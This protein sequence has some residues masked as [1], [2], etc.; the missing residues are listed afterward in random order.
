MVSVL[1]GSTADDGRR[2][3]APMTTGGYWLQGLVQGQGI[4]PTVARLAL[5]HRLRGFVRNTSNGVQVEVAGCADDIQRFEQ[6]MQQKLHVNVMR[7]VCSDHPELTNE[8]E[9]RASL[10]S[11]RMKTIVPLD[12]AVCATCLDEVRSKDSRR[13]QYPFTTCTRCGPRYSILHEMPFDRERTSM[14]AFSMCGDCLDEYHHPNDRRFH[15]QTNSCAGCGPK[16]W[17]ENELFAVTAEAIEAIVHVAE[18]ILDGGIAAVKGIGGYQLV[19]DATNESVVKRLRDRKRRPTKPF[20]IMVTDIEVAQRF[21]IIDSAEASLLSSGAN[22]I[23]L[24]R[25]RGSRELAPS[26]HPRLTELG[27]MLSTTPLHYLLSAW[28]NRPLV[29]TSGNAHGYPIV[30]EIERSRTELKGIADVWMHH[31]REIVRPID[32]SVV[33]CIAGRSMT[34]RLARGMAPLTIPVSVREPM[35]GVGGHQKVAI[36][37]CTG[38]EMVLAPH[39]G[40]MDSE[41]S[42]ERFQIECAKIALLYRLESLPLACDLHPDFFTTNWASKKDVEVKPVQHHHAHLA[43]AILEHGLEGQMVLG[44]TFDGTGYGTDGTIW[45]GEVLAVN[46]SDCRRVAHLRSFPLVGGDEGIKSP[47]RSAIAILGQSLDSDEFDAW[48]KK[49][50]WNTSNPSARRLVYQSVMTT[51]MGR[52]FDAV[53][54][55][56]FPD[57]KCKYEG[58]AAMILEAASDPHEKAAYAFAY[59]EGETI[60][61]DWR[62]LIRQIVSDVERLTPGRIAMKFHRAVATLVVELAV[63]FPH[64]VPVVCGGVFQNRVLLTLINHY[65][66][67]QNCPV[68]FPGRIPTGD[69]GLAVG[70][71]VVASSRASA[72]SKSSHIEINNVQELGRSSCSAEIGALRE[73]TKCV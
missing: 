51:S 34:I 40:D 44:F 31:D 71:L 43:A 55:I 72:Q 69:G 3:R 7:L 2:E 13:Y 24:L 12:I 33:R 37:I 28:V 10:T 39:L 65:A 64:H 32:D 62:P 16:C 29:V 15:S 63:R 20:P 22:P 5:G 1:R 61:I 38:E 58:E 36:A 54:A 21:A 35:L 47:Q 18:S 26:I 25:S 73:I 53:A 23:V 30:F 6:A 41:P 67:I 42:R 60:E 57:M 56:V 45:G 27:I 49:S 9:I 52:L 50:G 17:S 70:Q 11:E 68:K 66:T 19:C 48:I 14:A 4:R 46:G 59:R 8:F